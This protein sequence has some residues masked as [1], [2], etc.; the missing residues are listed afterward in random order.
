MV[1]IFVNWFFFKHRNY[2]LSLNALK[3]TKNICFNSKKSLKL[4]YFKSLNWPKLEKNRIVF[5][6]IVNSDCFS[7]PRRSL[8]C[9]QKDSFVAF[10]TKNA[11][12]CYFTGRSRSFNKF[13]NI[14]RIKLRNFSSRGLLNGLFKC[15]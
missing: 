4:R 7:L 2:S 14:S 3:S 6:F 10:F 9:L 12:F 5:K 1:L 15:N 8:A 11:N 13:F